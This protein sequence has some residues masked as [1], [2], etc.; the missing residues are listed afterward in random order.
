[1]TNKKSGCGCL[2]TIILSTALLIAGGYALSKGWQQYIWGTELT[3]L[4]AARI[5]PQDV[6]ITT[7]INTDVE[8][9][10]ELEVP[11][12]D[13]LMTQLSQ[14]IE[15][16][17]PAN[18]QELNF[19]QDLNPWLGDA[20]IAW[21]PKIVPARGSYG[22]QP[23][24]D[25]LLIFGIENPLKAYRFRQRIKSAGKIQ[26]SQSKFRGVTITTYRQSPTCKLYLAVLGNK[27]VVTEKLSLMHQ[28]ISTFQGEPAL[29]D[30][31][32]YKQV[33]RQ[34][35]ELK[36]PL[37]KVYLT[38]DCFSSEGDFPLDSVV[39]GMG[40]ETKAV[41]L[42]TVT[43][44]NQNVDWQP[45]TSNQK[46]I[47]DNF[48]QSTVA[49]IGGQ[50]D[51]K[52]IAQAW[53]YFVE[54]Y[55]P[56]LAW[57]LESEYNLERW[58]TIT[59]NYQDLIQL[60][61]GEFAL[62]VAINEADTEADLSAGLIL[63]MSDHELATLALEQL[64]DQSI[65]SLFDPGGYLDLSSTWISED[66]LLLTWNNNSENVVFAQS[67]KSILDNP[68]FARF[69]QDLPRKN[70]GYAFLD[71]EAIVTQINEIES[72]VSDSGFALINQLESISFNSIYQ[73]RSNKIESDLLVNFK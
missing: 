68:K 28:A 6:V 38:S 31:R 72:S 2:S 67:D 70:L 22:L 37:V 61:D 16:S 21:F 1:M 43:N 3:P 73:K 20:T 13:R 15:Q 51:T 17:L 12:V 54:D 36:N 44:L 34:K 14:E 62:G 11:E 4:E 27:L 63:T 24:A 52:E 55:Y 60:I 49:L 66:N 69:Y 25:Y 71:L 64:E 42:K 7:Y 41:R 65:L 53:T 50:M 29:A 46:S 59:S 48:P 39:F 5:I 56:Y 33:V 8:D 9:W 58:L 40:T 18:M 45:A 10:S 57:Y 23:D 30:S 35:L 26:Y 47:L 19:Q 32:Q